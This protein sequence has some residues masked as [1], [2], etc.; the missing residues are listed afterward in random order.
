VRIFEASV[1]EELQIRRLDTR[2][3]LAV[4][5][6]WLLK[7]RATL[8]NCNGHTYVSARGSM[9]PS[10]DSKSPSHHA[11][12]DLLKASYILYDIVL[13]DESSPGNC[14]R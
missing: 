6:W 3:W 5:T 8:A 4:A 9:S 12:I 10:T 11:Y 2:D 14:K 1:T 7:A 13:K